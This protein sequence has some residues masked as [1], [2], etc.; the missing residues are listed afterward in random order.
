MPAH[1]ITP[2]PPANDDLPEK[3]DTG[4]GL[5][6][7]VLAESGNL[8]VR[9]AQS[10]AEIRA[11]QALR[12]RVFYQE[13]SAEP[14]P[15]MA[16]VERDFDAFDA[17]TDHL[18]VIDRSL[19]GDDRVV[20]TYRLLRQEVADRHAGF[21]STGEFKFDE[22]LEKGL[23][24]RAERT[25]Q[26]LELGRSCVHPDYRANSTI[27]L[28]WR[29]ISAYVAHHKIGLMFGCASLEGT[30]PDELAV[31]LSFLYH[32]FLG[33]SPLA[34]EAL[35]ELKVEMN[36]LP[37]EAIDMKKALRGLPPLIKGYLRLGCYIGDGAV[38]DKQ[39]GTTDVFIILPV[40]QISER[41]VKRYEKQTQ[42]HSS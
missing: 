28:L 5:E 30:D 4:S 41:Y 10:D 13:M 3:S 25:T 38:I 8:R 7:V 15:D 18:L 32:N 21:Y 14:T 6:G 35:P 11:S 20:G 39:F 33:K 24:P 27:Q 40:D 12:Y 29:G 16:A 36:R 26:F 37:A 34:A 19:T 42:E 17:Y 1:S 31:P 22:L 9:L 2:P 23:G